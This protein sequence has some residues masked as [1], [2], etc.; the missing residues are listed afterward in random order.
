M[1]APTAVEVIHRSSASGIGNANSKLP[2]VFYRPELDALRFGAFLMVFVHHCPF[3]ASHPKLWDISEAGGYGVCI[4]FLLSAYLIATLLLREKERTGAIHAKKFFLRRLLR[5]WPLYF[6]AM[7]LGIVAGAFVP[8]WHVNTAAIP[9]LLLG[10]GNFFVAH[11]G[12]QLGVIG[13]L[14]SL[15]VEE[16]FYVAVP[17][18]MKFGGGRALQA[19]SWVCI[20]AAYPTLAFL[21]HV[22]A[23]PQ[24]G[25][26]VN[27]LV[28]FQ[29][30]G[31]GTLIAIFLHRRTWKLPLGGRLALL[32]G[33]LAGLWL[34]EALFHLQ[35]ARPASSSHLCL[36]YLMVLASCVSIFLAVLGAQVTVPSFIVYLGKISFG[37]YVFHSFILSA[38]FLPGTGVLHHL[39]YRFSLMTAGLCL[40]VTIAVAA[41]SYELFEKRILRFKER[42]AYIKSSAAALG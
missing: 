23:I 16:Q 35:T 5:I 22:G 31:A 4:F 38:A 17:S 27:S 36:G 40:L 30:F 10:A 15:S 26:W 24:T 42:F 29:F 7:A 2:S 28:Q 20:A 21:G 6:L 18:L 25:V 13:P 1:P 37:L 33:G 11:A 3:P 41:G 39:A 9:Y 12:W 8:L 19:A 34:T 14:W 32:S